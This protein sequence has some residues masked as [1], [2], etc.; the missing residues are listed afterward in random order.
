[1]LQIEGLHAHYG[2]AHI[3]HDVTLMIEAGTSVGLLGRNGMGKTT[4]IRSLMGYLRPTA[5]CIQWDGRD[6]TGSPPERMARLGIGYVPEGRGIFPNLSVRENLVMAARPGVDG[7]SRLDPGA[8]PRHVPASGRA[9]RPRRPAAFRRRAADARDRPRADDQSAAPGARRGHRGPGAAGRRG[10]L[11]RRR[12]HPRER[13][14][15]AG[16]RPRLPQGRRAFRPARGPAEGPRRPRRAR[17][18]PCAATAG[19]QQFLGV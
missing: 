19:W 12:R 3:L 14:G 8:R 4:L 5:G 7:A 9:A 11:A 10:D 13:H 6:V 2:A 17:R 1:M 15:H 16:R 18:T